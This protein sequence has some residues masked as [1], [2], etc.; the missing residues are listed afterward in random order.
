MFEGKRIEDF[1]GPP[2]LLKGPTPIVGDFFEGVQKALQVRYGLADAQGARKEPI[3]RSC[4][5]LYWRSSRSDFVILH[6]PSGLLGWCP[7]VPVW[8]THIRQRGLIL[9]ADGPPLRTENWSA[10]G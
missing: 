6:S 3:K 9:L 7:A 1:Q 2:L 10:C 5:S 4:I 8:G